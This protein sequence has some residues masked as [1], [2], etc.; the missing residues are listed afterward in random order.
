G[1]FAGNYHATIG[2]YDVTEGYVET[3]IPL[4]KDT[5]WAKSLDL[6]GGVR[7]TGY[8]T[9]GYVTT[10]KVGATYQPID[11]VRFRATRSRD[12]RAPNRSELF[13]SAVFNSS[14]ITDPFRNNASVFYQGSTNGNINLKPEKADTTGLGVVVTPGFFPGFSASFDYYN[15]DINDA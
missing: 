8:S 10:W 12:I 3:V 4:A 2:S 7:A 11:D 1:W 9:A 13:A 6:N 15:I 14:V 5:A